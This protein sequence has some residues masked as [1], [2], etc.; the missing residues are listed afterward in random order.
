MASEYLNILVLFVIGGGFAVTTVVLSQWIGP[1]T[2]RRPQ[3]LS[4]YECGVDVIEV[5]ASRNRHDIRFYVVAILFLL[6]DLEVVFLY[7]WA[8]IFNSV[9]SLG[10]FLMIEMGIFMGVLLVGLVYIWKKDVLV[11]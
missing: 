2:S 5:P 4:P 10:P 7:P 6:F 9:S 3:D 1:K 11:W 8:Y